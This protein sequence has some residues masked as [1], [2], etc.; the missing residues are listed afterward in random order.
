MDATIRQL[1]ENH[2]RDNCNV[3]VMDPKGY[4]V[5]KDAFFKEGEWRLFLP[6]NSKKK[7]DSNKKGEPVPIKKMRIKEAIKVMLFS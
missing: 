1:I 2:L 3:N 5:P 7:K 6:P 4:T